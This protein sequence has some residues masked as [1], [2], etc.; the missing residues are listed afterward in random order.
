MSKRRSTSLVPLG[1]GRLTLYDCQKKRTKEDNSSDVIG[2]TTLSNIDGT[3]TADRIKKDDT[4]SD[5]CM[6]A[7]ETVEFCG[8]DELAEDKM[9]LWNLD[10]I[11]SLSSNER[12]LISEVCVLLKLILVMLSTNAVS[13]RW[14]SALRRIKNYLRNTM[15]QERLNHF[16]CTN[17]TQILLA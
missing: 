9:E 14:F 15:S 6:L 1:V 13:E 16:M 3:G 7:V 10:Y 8:S 17:S 2:L 12:L 4:C 11:L 5:T